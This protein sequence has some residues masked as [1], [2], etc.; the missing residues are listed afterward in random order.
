MIWE[1]RNGIHLKCSEKILHNIG[2]LLL[3]TTNYEVGCTKSV[4]TKSILVTLLWVALV[5]F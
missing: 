5:V 3:N 4:M 2:E 1:W